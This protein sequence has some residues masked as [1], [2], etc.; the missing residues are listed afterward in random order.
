MSTLINENV[1]KRTPS[2]ISSRMIHLDPPTCPH[3]I[4]LTETCGKCEQAQNWNRFY[5]VAVLFALIAFAAV[6][7]DS[8][9]WL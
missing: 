2:G 3:G 5:F 6:V 8:L 1:S 4:R 9:G 7:V